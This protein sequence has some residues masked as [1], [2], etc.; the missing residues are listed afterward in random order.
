MSVSII[1]KI[2][3]PSSYIAVFISKQ[4]MIRQFLL[5]PARASS[6]PVRSAAHGSHGMR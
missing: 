5:T 3:R 6:A 2:A 4:F 1:S